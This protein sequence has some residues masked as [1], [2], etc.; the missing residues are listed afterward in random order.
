VK[1]GIK[2][3]VQRHFGMLA[4][5][6][7]LKRLVEGGEVTT[8][9]DVLAYFDRSI[10]KQM[11]IIARKKEQEFQKLARISLCIGRIHR[12]KPYS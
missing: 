11:A 10:S 12:V 5:K 2:E 1:E 6:D 7:E 9:D 8:A 3:A 4:E